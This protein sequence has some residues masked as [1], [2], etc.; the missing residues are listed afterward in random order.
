MSRAAKLYLA[1]AVPMTRGVNTV[2]GMGVTELP[3]EAQPGLGGPRAQ[4]GLCPNAWPC[5][6]GGDSPGPNPRAPHSSVGAQTHGLSE[7]PHEGGQSGHHLHWGLSQAMS[8]SMGTRADAST[9]AIR[10]PVRLSHVPGAQ[11]SRGQWTAE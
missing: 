6:Q 9:R 1:T 3:G 11:V 7:L 10:A 2:G 4:L 5:A 8:M